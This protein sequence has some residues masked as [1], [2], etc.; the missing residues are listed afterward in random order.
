MT[1]F[2]WTT[3][4]IY[5]ILSGV[6]LSVV[7]GSEYSSP[8]VAD[9]EEATGYSYSQVKNVTRND[10]VVYDTFNP[11]RRMCW[12]PDVWGTYKFGCE[13]KDTWLGILWLSMANTVTEQEVLDA[14]DPDKNY[15]KIVYDLGGVYQTD[16][17]IYP[18]MGPNYTFIYYPLEASLGNNSCTIMLGTN[19]TQYTRFDIS[20]LTAPVTGFLGYGMPSELNIILGTIWW[21]LFALAIAKLGLG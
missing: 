15:S 6:W 1:V 9:L 17:Y 3:L 16:V 18:L 4:V 21:I 14:W 19:Y 5:T 20:F 8:Y 7:S 11:D 12:R 10:C 13:R 2:L